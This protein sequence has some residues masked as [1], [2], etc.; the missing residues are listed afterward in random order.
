VDCPHRGGGGDG[1]KAGVGEILADHAGSLRLGRHQ[2]RVVH[3][4]VACR[5]GE[6]GGHLEECDQCGH[7]R[8]A[9]HSCR[10]RHCPRCGTLDQALWAEA[11]EQSLLPVPY[12]HVVFT[13]PTSLHP[14]FRRVP[15]V[16]LD[17]LFAATAETLLEV[18][19]RNWGARIGFSAVLHTWTQ[20]LL[21]HPH[22]HCLVPGGGLSND[23][24]QWIACDP[25][26]FLP[27]DKLRSVFQGKLLSKLEAAHSDNVFALAR[28]FGQQLLESAA[29]QSWVIYAKPPLAGPQQVVRYVSRYTRKIAIS[30]SRILD[31]DGSNVRFRWRDRAHGNRPEVLPLPGAEFARRFVLHILPPHFVRIRHYGLLSN[32]VREASLARCRALVERG[33]TTSPAPRHQKQDR[34]LACLRLFRKDPTRCPACGQGR[35]QTH[36]EW[37]PAHRFRHAELMPR[38]P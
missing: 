6:L 25:G 20:K 3:R 27:Y 35:M 7:T 9:Y 30:N 21:L 23:A 2:A 26:F 36:N 19:H 34:A 18:A 14:F 37:R 28:P 1:R 33:E 13:I 31:Y 4:L 32:R 24:Q 11:Q 29:R 8:M 38:A 16:A 22:V 15:S 12:F 10:D 17:L 5:T